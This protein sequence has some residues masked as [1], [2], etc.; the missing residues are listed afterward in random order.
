MSRRRASGANGCCGPWPA[1]RRP[2]R[3]CTDRYR[4]CWLRDATMTLTS[5][6]AAGYE[7]EAREWRE[8][9]L[10]AMAGD[11]PALQIM[12]GPISVL[13]AAGRHHDPDLA[14][15]RRL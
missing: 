5:L 4:F 7:Q 10:R 14:D 1:T 12:Y 13:L 9:L 6:M 11:P 2:C 15:G 3:S 8:W